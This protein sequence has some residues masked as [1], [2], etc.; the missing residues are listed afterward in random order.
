MCGIIEFG[1]GL[2]RKNEQRCLKGGRWGG[3]QA[4]GPALT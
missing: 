4:F 3:S 1:F 2:M